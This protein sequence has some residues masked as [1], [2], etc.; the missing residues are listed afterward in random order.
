MTDVKKDVKVRELSMT[1]VIVGQWVPDADSPGI[2]AF[3]PLATQPPAG[4]EDA[5]EVE[6][7]LRKAG[8]PGDYAMIRAYTKLVRIAKIE[9]VT[10]ELVPLKAPVATKVN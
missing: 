6:T 9:K 10:S 3:V 2:D 8:T 7:W 5:R 4:V 1:G